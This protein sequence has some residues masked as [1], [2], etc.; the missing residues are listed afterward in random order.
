MTDGCVTCCATSRGGVVHWKCN[1]SAVSGS[2]APTRQKWRQGRPGANGSPI[3]N[4]TTFNRLASQAKQERQSW[5]DKRNCHK[6]KAAA[7]QRCRHQA[8]QRKQQPAIGHKSFKERPTRRG[9]QPKVRDSAAP[10]EA[11]AEA[12]GTDRQADQC[13][14]SSN[15]HGRRGG[16]WEAGTKKAGN[17]QISRAGTCKPTH[18]PAADTATPGPMQQGHWAAQ[19]AAGQQ[20]KHTAA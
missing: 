13:C 17:S 18:C 16:A 14:I 4:R 12:A 9:R 10:A 2:T 6:R 5:W 19:Q 7:A 20:P 11:R 1:T 3:V 15:R 8:A